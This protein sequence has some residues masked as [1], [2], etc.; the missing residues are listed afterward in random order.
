MGGFSCRHMADRSFSSSAF[1][2]RARRPFRL[3]M[4]FC[5]Q[6][7]EM[8]K[9]K[10]RFKPLADVFRS[11]R[12]AE[13]AMHVQLARLAVLYEDLQIEWAGAEA[14]EIKALERTGAETRRFYFVR[15][16]LATL[17]EIEQ[18]FHMLNMNADFKRVKARMSS[19]EQRAWN[20]A[21]KFFATEHEFLKTWRNDI[22]GHFSDD[23]A[24]Y[25]IDDMHPTTV[26]AIE[27]YRRGR[28]ADVK[29]PFAYELVAVAMTRNMT[30]GTETVDQFL[31]RAFTFLKDAVAHAL[32]GMHIVTNGYLYDRFK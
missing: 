14:D 20:A 19:D 7:T 27:V 13:K 3:C 24:T 4:V 21:V 9:S 28:G 18:A 2:R 11:S 25:A 31:I 26:G 32:R 5:A 1:N 30:H 29:M 17:T 15:R 12:A 8:L 22:G 16:T 6:S 10:T 23:A